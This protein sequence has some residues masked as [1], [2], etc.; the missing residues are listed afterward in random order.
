[1]T[2][3]ELS[4]DITDALHA[5]GNDEL[6]VVD[7]TTGQV[8]VVVKRETLDEA[9]EALRI[10]RNVAAIQQGID[11]SDA[12]QIQPAREALGALGERLVSRHQ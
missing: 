5:V 7:P 1:M 3:K 4:P 2:P 9:R 10:H 8:Y 12:G 11:A 6:S